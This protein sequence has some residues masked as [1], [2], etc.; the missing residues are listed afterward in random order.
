MTHSAI[1][2]DNAALARSFIEAVERGAHGEALAAFLHEDVQQ[3]ELPNRLFA[4]GARRDLAAILASADKGQKVLR[5]QRYEV[6]NLVASGSH[7][8][9]EMRWRG[10][11]AVPLG[12]LQPGDALSGQFA[13]FLEIEDGKIRSMRNYD[14]YDAF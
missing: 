1:E 9:I 4:E 5:S 3:H 13:F 14:C 8:A 10:E 6:L 7:V 2:T 11:L 12:K